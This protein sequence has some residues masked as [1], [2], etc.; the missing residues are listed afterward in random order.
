MKMTVISLLINFHVLAT[1]L[2]KQFSNCASANIQDDT[3]DDV[4]LKLLCKIKVNSD[5][6]IIDKVIVKK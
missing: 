5:K 4:I 1:I 6:K 3:K 2:L